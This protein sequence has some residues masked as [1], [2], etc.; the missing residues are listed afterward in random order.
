MAEP[1]ILARGANVALPAKE[2]TASIEWEA[3]EKAGVYACLIGADGNV[4]TAQDINPGYPRLNKPSGPIG[5]SGPQRVSYDID[6][7]SMPVDVA[8]IIF[9]VVAGDPARFPR[10][11]PRRRSRARTPGSVPGAAAPEAGAPCPATLRQRA[12]FLP[13]QRDAVKRVCTQ[14]T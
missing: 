5:A 11:G 7:R 1:H 9:C 6:V 10:E 3:A 14:R 13:N 2:I 4:R 8:K 12:I